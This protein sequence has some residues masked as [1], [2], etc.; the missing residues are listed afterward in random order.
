MYNFIGDQICRTEY[1]GWEKKQKTCL[2]CIDTNTQYVIGIGVGHP[3]SPSLLRLVLSDERRL[4]WEELSVRNDGTSGVSS[5]LDTRGL[6]NI[7]VKTNVANKLNSL[8]L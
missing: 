2:I 8:S 5:L 6:K 1:V 7:K 3:F 4:G